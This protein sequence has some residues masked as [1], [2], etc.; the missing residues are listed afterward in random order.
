MVAYLT[1]C[2]PEELRGRVI[3]KVRYDRDAEW[4]LVIR[5]LKL[6]RPE[7]RALVEQLIHALLNPESAHAPVIRLS[8]EDDQVDSD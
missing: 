6:L 7:H 3:I 8:G 2:I 5:K 4:Q 1:D